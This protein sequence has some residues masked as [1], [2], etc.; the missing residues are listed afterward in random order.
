ME[1]VSLQDWLFYKQL[2]HF[3]YL[4]IGIITF[5]AI[6]SKRKLLEIPWGVTIFLT[7]L[8]IYLL[9]NFP[10]II[11]S[12]SDKYNYYLEAQNIANGRVTD[13]TSDIGFTALTK[14]LV[15]FPLKFYFYFLAIL[16]VGGMCFF[17]KSISKR[18]AGLLFIGM[19]LNFMFVSY[20]TN[21]IR[22]GVA[23]SIL[24]TAI[25]CRKNKWLC[26]ALLAFAVSV[27]KSWALPAICYL[28]AR[29]RDKTK[30][31]FG[32]WLLSIPISAIAGGSIQTLFASLIGDERSSYFTTG[33]ANTTYKIGF[34]LD[35][36]LY[37][38]APIVIGYYYI[39]KKKFQDK[40]YKNIY[41]MY[42][43]ANTFWILVIR[44][45][46]SDRFAYLSWF[47]Y[48]IVLLY[49][50]VTAPNYIPNSKRLAAY[51]IMGLTI[52]YSLY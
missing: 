50:L 4:A 34:R 37:S 28:L 40:L 46:F 38:C 35:F 23:S 6:F 33:I 47:L 13:R 32:I 26:F 41:N 1:F 22:A 7:V 24:L 45:N 17:C 49:P 43:L 29:Y 51:T 14:I 3:I 52:F 10:D 9:G 27:H 36:I 30:L 25:G 11:N 15:T 18:N 8:S 16:Y 21:T 39:Y 20:G 31:F 19:L 42:I 2:I 12:E 48:S 5:L 44:A